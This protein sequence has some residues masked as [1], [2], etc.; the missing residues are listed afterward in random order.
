MQKPNLQMPTYRSMRL[1]NESN[2]PLGSD[3]SWL[4]YKYLHSNHQPRA[5]MDVRRHG[6]MANSHTPTHTPTYKYLRLVNESN[7]PPGSDVSWLLYKYLH[8]NHQRGAVMRDRG[9]GAM[10]TAT[11]PHTP[12]RT[13]C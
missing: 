4:L 9:H 5:V 12:P 8:S 13:A 7:T 1:V 11:P 3:V 6:A 2:T 10:P